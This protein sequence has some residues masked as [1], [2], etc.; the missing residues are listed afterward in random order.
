MIKHPG[1][2]NLR[3]KGYILPYSSK[4]VV[5]CSSGEDKT[6]VRV[7]MVAGKSLVDHTAPT[8]LTHNI[9]L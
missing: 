3:K 7:G 8:D 4:S 6:S 9:K 1:R 2:D 5:I